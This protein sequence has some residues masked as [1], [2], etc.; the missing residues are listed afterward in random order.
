VNDRA[1]HSREALNGKA[2]G[3]SMPMA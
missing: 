3:I 2:S 1:S